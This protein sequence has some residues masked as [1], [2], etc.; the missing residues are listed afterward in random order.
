MEA[1]KRVAVNT[2]IL[3]ARM[4]ITV[5]I[6]LYV[7][8]L[9]LAALGTEDFGIF[10]V[11]GGAIAMLTFLNLAMTS[12][13]QRFMSYAEGEGDLEKQ[14]YIFNVSVILHFLIAVIVILLLEAAGYF[15][16]KG[17]LKIPAERLPVA[18]LIFQFMLVSTF[19]TIISVPY[20]AVINAHENM[21][22]VA[23]LGIVE[24]VIKLAIAFYITYTSFDKLVLYGLAMAALSIFLLILKRIYC[25]RKYVEVQINFRKYR[26]KSLFKEMTGFAGWSLLNSGASIITM[27]G[28]SIILNTFFGVLVNAAQ[29][30]AAQVSGQLMA[31]STT[32]LK[33][34]EPVIVKSEGGK[35][36]KQML[37]ASMTGNKLSYFL[38]VF[39][40]A[41]AILEMPYVLG[42]WLKDVP[43][44]AVVFCRLRLIAMFVIQLTV[45]F[46]T[47]IK[48]V[49]EI[50]QF[51]FWNS[52]IWAMLLPVS[53]LL[54]KLGASP[55]T[56]Y[57]IFIFMYAAL[58]VSSVYFLKRF[59]GLSL[60]D[61]LINVVARCFSSSAISIGLASIPLFFM[62]PGIERLIIVVATNSVAFILFM[63]LIGLKE[64]EKQLFLSAFKAALRKV[65]IKRLYA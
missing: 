53:Y 37:Q 60:K 46:P 22:L 30:I 42:V 2:G 56:L 41:P 5:F 27:Q 8:R 32:M 20:D 62:S 13:T 52:I 33:A 16:F 51:S 4:A 34:L 14:K 61:F 49:G 10:N 17:I 31:F 36:R 47:A 44:Y 19:F 1:A 65:R 63:F 48:A 21:L 29:G 11:V 45:T 15:L 25:H 59:G 35:N 24:A 23:I 38:L 54:F 64:N 18:K 39:F 26:N 12:A 57:V 6:S 55:E 40:A 9:V 7:T 50:K 3:Y 58:S 43:E 28:I